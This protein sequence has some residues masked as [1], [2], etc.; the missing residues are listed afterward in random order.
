MLFFEARKHKD[1]YLWLAKSPG[2][3]SAKFHVTNGACEG[4]LEGPGGWRRGP[5]CNR[6]KGP[7]RGAQPFCGRGAQRQGPTLTAM[8]GGCTGGE[9]GGAGS[10]ALGFRV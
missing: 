10:A 4:W 6:A 3:P 9:R 7:R 5:T 8:R 1:L 2:G